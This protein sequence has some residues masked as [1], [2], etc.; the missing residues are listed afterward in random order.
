MKMGKHTL[1]E[2]LISAAIGLFLGLML[3][4]AAAHERAKV[5][6]VYEAMSSEQI[7]AACDV[8]NVV[9]LGN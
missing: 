8:K 1:M 9:N 7:L 6:V 3:V 2:N 5:P 4:T